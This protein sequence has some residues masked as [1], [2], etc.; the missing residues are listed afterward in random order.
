LQY[1][2]R[3]A[4]ARS[5]GTADITGED[6]AIIPSFIEG[7]PVVEIGEEAFTEF[8]V[9]LSKI[10]VPSTVRRIR[11]GAFKMCM[12][13]TELVLHDGLEEIGAEALYLTP[14]TE[15]ALPDT[16][17]VMEEPW[18]LS[19]IRI[20][21]SPEHSCFFTDGFCLYR[22]KEAEQELLVAC[23][24]EERTVYR[25]ADGTTV[26]GESAFAGNEM[27]ERGMLPGSVHTIRAS[28]F[29]EC[30]R[31]RE[32]VLPETDWMQTDSKESIVPNPLGKISGL[33]CI[34]AL[35]FSHCICLKEIYLP[36]T[37]ENIGRFAVSDTFG[38]SETLIGLEK[39]TVSAANLHF[40]ADEN[41]LF[42]IGDNNDR[43]L[44][45]YFGLSSAY[46][47]PADVTRILP[48][49][50]RRAK[51]R[52]CR[53]PESVRDVGEDAFREC[54]ALEELELE[55][56]G[57]RL[58][59]PHQPVY[60]KDEITELFYNAEREERIRKMQAAE[61]RGEQ[62][63]GR[64]SILDLPDKWKDFATYYPKPWRET[65]VQQESALQREAIA[66]RLAAEQPL[67]GKLQETAGRQY[68]MNSG[69]RLLYDY[70]GYDALFPTYLSLPEKCGMACCRLKYP[71]CLS[72]ETTEEYRTFVTENLTDILRDISK[73][74]DIDRLAL[75]AE[76]NFFTEDNIGSCLDVFARIGATKCTGFLLNYQ[77]EHFTEN[78]FDF[79]L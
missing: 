73:T 69:K 22:K 26:I 38:W 8:G 75:L 60:R 70:G 27:L 63:P 57:M 29:E 67:E 13:L 14:L 18:N 68:T 30:R 66:L 54:A 47:I 12:S 64:W 17:C 62:K 58:Y 31:L 15:L 79:S 11:K 41:A 25:V 39:I 53:I 71:I 65:A 48:G 21:V 2:P 16:V 76:L 6:I 72:K 23:Q 5:D 1:R 19:A 32:V 9:L 61:E 46:Q 74:Q 44:V 42:E 36:S 78:D 59:V 49:A 51:F 43:Y 40:Q 50:F 33:R 28:A 3:E 56:S 52:K 35:A 55:E 45:K 24:Q 7:S 37:V 10:E 77:R 20:L 34:G 4:F